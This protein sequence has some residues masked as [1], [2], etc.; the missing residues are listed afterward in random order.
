MFN[1]HLTARLDNGTHQRAGKVDVPFV[2]TRKPG[3]VA[4]DG[5]PRFKGS[6]GHVPTYFENVATYGSSTTIWV[7]EV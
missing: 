4:C 6:T 1:L 5:Y 3:S 2:K 7:I